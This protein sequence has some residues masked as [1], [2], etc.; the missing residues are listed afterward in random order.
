M[1]IPA[2]HDLRRPQL[3]VDDSTGA[4]F[5]A[6]NCPN[7]PAQR[8]LRYVATHRHLFSLPA[9]VKARDDAAIAAKMGRPAEALGGAK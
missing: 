2:Y 5:H 8:T 1:A 3:I 4:V 6:C 9:D 7:Q